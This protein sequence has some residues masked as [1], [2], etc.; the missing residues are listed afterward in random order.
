MHLSRLTREARA[1]QN[2]VKRG[3]VELPEHWRWSSAR[4]YA[5][6]EG[7]IEVD[8]AWLEDGKLELPGLGCQAG[9]WQPWRQGEPGRLGQPRQPGRRLGVRRKLEL[10]GVLGACFGRSGKAKGSRSRTVCGLSQLG[11]EA[12]S[13]TLTLQIPKLGVDLQR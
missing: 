3:Y 1:D 6:G 8:T 10:A 13:D 5:G 9:A 12:D 11:F 2:P 7:L 4:S